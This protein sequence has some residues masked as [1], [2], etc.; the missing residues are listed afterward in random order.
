MEPREVLFALN[1]MKGIGWK[2][3]LL[4]MKKID[5][6]S[7][8]T[9]RQ[10]ADWL[11]EELPGHQAETIRKE[12]NKNRVAERTQVYKDADVQ[13][14][15]HYDKPYPL[16]LRQTSEPP[17]VLYLKG[18]KKLLENPS[19]AIVGTRTP[20]AYGKRTA[21]TL[22][23]ELA[24]YG[25]SIVSGLARGVDS[26]AHEGA[27]SKAG[28]TVAVLGHSIDCV[29]PPEN[30]LLYNRIGE[31]GLLLSEFPFGTPPHPGLFP[32]RNRIIAGLSLGTIVVEAALKSGSLITAD[33][34]LE[35]SRDVFA[36][37][38]PITSPK[39]AGTNSLIQQGAKLVTSVKDILVEYAD[40]S[41]ETTIIPK[42]DFDDEI[43]IEE[44]KILQQLSFEPMTVDTLLDEAQTNFGHLHTILLS[45]LMKKKIVQV[46]GSA[47]VLS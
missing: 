5:N 2:T 35:E 25:Y 30:R 34:A 40:Y 3:I 38:G 37:P 22:A 19:L 41:T 23:L 45:L 29:Y 46:A 17:W 27:L 33:Q 14:V 26:A 9:D 13:I 18:R 8:L 1:E 31:E 4:L 36:V 24:D 47:Y 44:Q 15:T 10:A 21:N 12:L 43:S 7:S 42:Q 11:A 28:S 32:R 16:L 39:S 6:I 20:T